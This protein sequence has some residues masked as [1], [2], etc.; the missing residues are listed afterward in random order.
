MWLDSLARWAGCTG[1][2]AICD[3]ALVAV[4]SICALSGGRMFAAQRNIG[5]VP[6]DCSALLQPPEYANFWDM[7]HFTAQHH[8]QTTE[9]SGSLGCN[10]HVAPATARL[11]SKQARLRCETNFPCAIV[12]E[13]KHMTCQC[14]V[15][16][17]QDGQSPQ[18]A[19]KFTYPTQRTACSVRMSNYM[20][21]SHVPLLIQE[22]WL[23][24]VWPKTRNLEKSP[25]IQNSSR[26][27]G[28][29]GDVLS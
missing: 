25:S 26:E 3:E 1:H 9:S 17:M 15:R 12:R 11:L 14:H 29:G 4:F 16:H 23:L 8:T 18:P 21:T 28:C 2:A 24:S 13:A 19:S 10:L 27:H 22:A 7:K 6:R 5:T 20:H